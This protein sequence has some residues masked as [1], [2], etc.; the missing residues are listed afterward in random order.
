VSALAIPSRASDAGPEQGTPMG[1]RDWLDAAADEIRDADRCAC[2]LV[3]AR[4]KLRREHIEAAIDMLRR[5]LEL[6]EETL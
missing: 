3:T 4:T 2:T 5:S 6:V 1:F